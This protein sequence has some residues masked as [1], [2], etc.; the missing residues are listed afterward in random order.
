MNSHPIPSEP[1]SP[2]P[3]DDLRRK[4]TVARPDEAGSLP[5]VGL[6][7]NTYTILVSGD[8]TGG[9]YC[10][11]DMHVMPGGG[12]PPHRHDFDESFTV[13]DG[14][15]ELTFRGETLVARKGETVNIPANAPH[16]FANVSGRTARLL[17]ACAPAGQDAFFREVGVPLPSRTAAA[18]ALDDAAKAE[19]GKKAGA[20]ALRY[21]TEF[22]KP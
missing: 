13:L 17:C 3:P 12:P 14:E 1:T 19:L 4:L 22:L 10:L 20:L 21:R 8:D 15:I 6:V 2:I 16:S 11:V 7:G 5:H 9:R 18:P